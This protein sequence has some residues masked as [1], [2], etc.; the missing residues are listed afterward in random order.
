MVRGIAEAATCLSDSARRC[1][2]SR[3][4]SEPG[5]IAVCL[6]LKWRGVFSDAVVLQAKKDESSAHLQAHLV[7]TIV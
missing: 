6:T 1:W 7:R 4:F 5:A 2:G 3:L